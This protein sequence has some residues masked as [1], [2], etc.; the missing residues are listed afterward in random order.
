M[1]IAW[2]TRSPESQARE[3]IVYDFSSRQERHFQWKED[4]TSTTAWGWE[5]D[6]SLRLNEQTVNSQDGTAVREKLIFDINTQASTIV[7]EI[8]PDLPD[9]DEDPTPFASF[10]AMDPKKSRVLYTVFKSGLGWGI[11]LRDLENDVELWRVY[12][13]SPGSYSNPYWANDGSRV[14][15]SFIEPGHDKPELFSISRDGKQ[16]TQLTALEETYEDYQVTYANW[17]PGGQ[18]IAFWLYDFTVQPLPLARL[19][20]LDL[21]QNRLIEACF[22]GIPA[23][24]PGIWLEDN[25]LFLFQLDV[26]EQTMLVIYNL[27]TGESQVLAQGNNR[28]VGPQLIGWI[29]F[30][31]P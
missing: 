12:G 14:L 3:L 16:I 8:Q 28:A 31:I 9:L 26:K 15:I 29:N 22:Q 4:W 19:H 18:R 27:A 5:S 6:T 20:I 10:K 7:R 13:Q 17:S 2:D 21:E 1:D 30:E 24:Y 23:T 25:N 11:A